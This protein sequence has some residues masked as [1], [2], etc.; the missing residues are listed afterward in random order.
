MLLHIA[1][2]ELVGRLR[3]I[4]TYVYFGV[5]FGIAFLWNA[6]AGGAFPGASV[7]FGAGGKVYINSPTSLMILLMVGGYLGTI[8]TAAIAGRATFQDVEHRATSFFFTA[9]ITKLQYLGG[10]Y[11]GAVLSGLVLYPGLALG[12]FAAA[13]APFIDPSRVGPEVRFAYLAPYATVLL[14]NLLFTSAIFFALSTLTRRMLP[15][16]VGAVVLVLGYLIAQNLTANIDNRTVAGLVDPFGIQAIGDVT[17]YWTIA[18]K[19]TRLV[20]LS[21]AL[22]WNRVLWTSAGAALLALTYARFSFAEPTTRAKR[23]AAVPSEPASVASPP[24]PFLDFSPRAS[25][26]VLVELTRLQLQETLKSVYFLV[27]VLAAVLFVI[28]TGLEADQLYGT[29]TYAVTYEVLEFLGGTFGLFVLVIIAFY[30]GELVW[31]ERDLRLAPIFDALPIPRWVVFTSKL[32]A[33]MA[34]QVVLLGVLFVASLLLQVAKGYF[35]FELGVYAGVLLGIQLPSYWILCCVAMLVHVVANNKYVGHFAMILYFVVGVALPALGFEHRLYRLGSVP[36]WKYSAMNGFGHFVRPIAAFELYWAALAFASVV[37]ANAL[38]V[39][40]AETRA[41]LRLRLAWQTRSRGAAAALLTSLLV[42]A[43]MG[44][45]IFW[46]T[47]HLNEY[48]TSRD[49][50]LDEAEAEKTYASWKDVP[51]PTLKGAKLAFDIFPEERRLAAR[52]SYALANE[53]DVAIPR[54][55]L[56]VPHR[57]RIEKVSFGRDERR[58]VADA[59]LG[60][61]V[62]DLPRPLSPHE[63]ATLDFELSYTNEGFPNSGGDTHLVYNGTFFNSELLPQVGYTGDEIVDDATRHK[64]GLAPKHMAQQGDPL[65]S[66]RNYA[67]SNAHWVDFDATVSTSPDQLAVA[68]GYL[69]REWTENGR[70]YFHYATEGKV[71]GFYAVLSARYA[72]LK[73]RWNDVAIEIDYQPGHTYDLER[74]VRGIKRSLD[75]FTVKFGPYQHRQVRIVEF[76]RY[77]KFAQ[78]FPNTI[79]FS[80]SIGFI[81]KVDDASPDDIDYPFYVTAHEVAHQWWAHQVISAD[82]QG[83]TFL[84]E[85][86][87]QYS[88]LMVMKHEY[89]ADK[90][91]KFL[92]YELDR[93]LHGRST[94]K[95]AE[96][97]LARVENEPYTHYAKGSLCMYALQDYLGED[98]VDAALA[99]LVA[100]WKFR[101]PPYPDAREL[102]ALFREAAPPEYQYVVADMFE[103]IT[104]YENRAA[105]ATYEKRAD[106]RFD[107]TVSVRAKKLR[108]SE[109][110][111]ETEV[112]VADY[113]DVGVLGAKG[114]VLALR[115]EKIETPEATFTFVVDEEPSKAGIDPLDKL[116]DRAPDDNVIKVELSTAP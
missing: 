58:S 42:F 87:S 3:M 46:N 24:P 108:A 107:V 19:N 60:Y 102:V 56:Q 95:R 103:E 77:E 49:K 106:G 74:M 70:R 116:V 34:V 104:L 66:M 76:P 78:S 52:G 71:L 43:G 96:L 55:L 6:I 39:R 64:Y 111:V 115:R 1:W 10:R 84:S 35:H 54:I 114:K 44:A 5:F 73:D 7:D 113:I 69:D 32:C 85:S 38:W 81:A 88:A 99:K 20:P 17:E 50:E 97:P 59:R 65:S 29:R 33:L 100:K 68:P 98:A 23:P 27:I 14:P 109:T 41:A 67:V 21:G 57:A 31:R 28:A 72:V 15:V 26:G 90:M 75:Y 9:P 22:L 12:A 62:Y 18:E 63:T 48:R 40:G 61:Y 110:G 25:A 37:V 8:V 83:A 16:Y 36:P 47:N 79:P 4:S 93:Y 53:S 91:K 11:L 94:A 51:Q 86:L 80:E 30:S 82:V 92:R 105:S 45:F 101:G 13:H 2:F 112:P 89:G